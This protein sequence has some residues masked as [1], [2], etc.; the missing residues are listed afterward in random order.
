VGDGV[1]PGPEPP[2]RDTPFAPRPSWTWVS[3][4]SWSSNSPEQAAESNGA[5]TRSHAQHGEKGVLR[6][7]DFI[8]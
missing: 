5:A 6:L 4:V 3:N 1:G 8:G 7:G 2:A